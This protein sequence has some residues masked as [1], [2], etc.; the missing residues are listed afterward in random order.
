MLV[1]PRRVEH[2]LDVAV[3]TDSF[4]KLRT[5]GVYY[6]SRPQRSRNSTG[7]I[8]RPFLIHQQRLRPAVLRT[9]DLVGCFPHHQ[10]AILTV[11]DVE[12]VAH[13]AA[14]IQATGVF[15]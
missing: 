9:Q 13:C 10:D 3:H 2:A 5:Q 8:R 12:K 15:Q 6:H 7:K 14:L 1:F 4:R 11:K